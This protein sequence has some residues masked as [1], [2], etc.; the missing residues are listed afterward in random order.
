MYL[1]LVKVRGSGDGI[2]LK[3]IE[4]YHFHIIM[5]TD[6]SDDINVTFKMWRHKNILTVSHRF[7]RAARG[8]Y[9]TFFE[10]DV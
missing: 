1:H 5:F 4:L 6:G 7:K 9:V 3:L 2:R 10:Q 8:S